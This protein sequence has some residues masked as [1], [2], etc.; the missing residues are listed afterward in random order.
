[1]KMNSARSIRA[2]SPIFTWG[3]YGFDRDR[4][5]SDCAS[6]LRLVKRYSLNINGEEN[7]QPALAAA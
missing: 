4:S 6:R 3:R 2:Y 5:S 1:M 7:E